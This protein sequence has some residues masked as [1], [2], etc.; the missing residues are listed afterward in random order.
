MKIDN[1]TCEHRWIIDSLVV[2][3]NPST[4][5]RRCSLCG[6]VQSDISGE[7]NTVR[8]GFKPLVKEGRGK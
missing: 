7:W 2:D 5:H 3:T 6:E 1:K 8:I 4:H